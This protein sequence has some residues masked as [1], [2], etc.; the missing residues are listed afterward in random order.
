MPCAHASWPGRGER[1]WPSRWAASTGP[2]TST[3][4]R[5]RCSLSCSR[6]AG[7]GPR[8]ISGVTVLQGRG[9]GG[10]TVHNT[11]LCKRIPDPILDEWVRERGIDGWDPATLRP[12][13]EATERDLSVSRLGPG[14]RNRQNALLARGAEALG[15]AHG[16]LSHNRVGC[17][18]SGFCE[19]GCSFN[20]KQNA[21]K[22]LIP[23]GLAAG[24]DVYADC[25]AREILVRRGRA[26]G[27]AGRVLDA[28]GRAT[29][30]FEIRAD[31]VVL[32]GSAV[33]TA[34]L[35]LRSDVPDPHDQ[36]GRHLHLHPGAPVAGVFEDEV[37][38]WQGIPQSVEVTELL[39][40]EGHRAPGLDRRQLRPPDRGRR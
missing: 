4:A 15:Y 17:V 32:A 35:L 29:A 8:P 34:A 9:V 10:S 40:V 2:A 11:N 30:P 19:L 14:E 37:L 5:T 16:Y 27:I 20:A 6:R 33:G 38:A 26:V 31:A 24:L 23:E 21:L 39:D 3:S 12:D 25:E 28:D 22:V 18:G 36:A 1:W 13:F 7:P